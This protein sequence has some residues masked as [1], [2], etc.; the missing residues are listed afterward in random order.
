M[1]ETTTAELA[2]RAMR[3]SDAWYPTSQRDAFVV[4]QLVT[5]DFKLKY[6]R[7]VLGIA[8]SV[9]NPLLMMCV[10]AV[11]FTHLMTRHD[12]SIP[13]FPIYLIL[14]NTAWHL[15][16]DATNAGMQS[17]IHAQSL[18]KKVRINRWVFPVQKVLFAVVNY[19]FS[20][21]AVGLVMLIFRWPL[22]VWALMLPLGVLYLT[23]FCIGLSL[24]LSSLAVFFRDVI[25]L[26]GVLLTAWMYLTPLF[27]S[28]TILPD[29]MQSIMRFNPMYL[30]ITFI[31]RCLLWRM[32]PGLLVHAG[33]IGF[34]LAMLGIGYAVFHKTEDRFI[35]FI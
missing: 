33:C 16:S 2:P 8:W 28:V 6:R 12:N 30:Y 34:A 23:I 26:W 10:Q 3:A 29:W 24:V 15:M 13:N 25:H 31:R 14:G 22:S 21:V 27:Y 19:V 7:S 5:K 1:S 4:K 35:L 32:N 17:I 11:V 18:L 20:L 9:L